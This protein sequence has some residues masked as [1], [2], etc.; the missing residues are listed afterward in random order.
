MVSTITR[1]VLGALAGAS[2]ML[3]AGVAS[4]TTVGECQALITALR[5]DTEAA[6]FVGKNAAKDEAGLIAKLD[7]AS[8]KLPQ[9]K[10]C[11]AKTKV[12]QYRDKVSALCGQG[13][14]VDNEDGSVTCAG[15]IEDAGEV[16]T[17]IAGLNPNCP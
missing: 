14:L 11:D 12:T 7:G 17:C 4:A 1:T 15:L 6:T 3:A 2:L 13:K 16:L 8:A 10:F 5:G 9:G